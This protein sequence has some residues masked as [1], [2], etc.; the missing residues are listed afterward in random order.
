MITVSIFEVIFFM[1]IILLISVL[2]GLNSFLGDFTIDICMGFNIISLVA[3]SIG[4]FTES[5]RD[6]I[7]YVFESR[8]WK[9]YLTNFLAIIAGG[10]MYFKYL[11]DL[12]GSAKIAGTIFMLIYYAIYL[13]T[14]GSFYLIE[15][16]TNADTAAH[17]NILTGVLISIVILFFTVLNIWN[18]GYTITKATIASDNNI[19]Y[20]IIE[21]K[22][23]SIYDSTDGCIGILG[24]YRVTS[25]YTM[26]CKD[27]VVY[28]AFVE[29][30]YTHKADRSFTAVYYRTERLGFVESCKLTPYYNDIVTPELIRK[31]DEVINQY[32]PRIPKFIINLCLKLYHNAT[33][34]SLYIAK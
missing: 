32:Y 27:M 21:N 17:T 31:R 2:R 29:N 3:F 25:K 33:F 15:D 23:V 22:G 30:R 5:V 9:C 6:A 20:Y 14:I 18:V 12:P 8:S 28:P 1:I 10:Y 11:Y 4:I 7:E 34:G 19:S 16:N 26:S 24:G 13:L